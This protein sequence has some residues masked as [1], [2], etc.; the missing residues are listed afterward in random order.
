M[1]HSK[2]FSAICAAVVL[3]LFAQSASAQLNQ[4]NIPAQF[5]PGEEELGIGGTSTKL[6]VI[7]NAPGEAYLVTTG[8][9]AVFLNEV[10]KEV[11]VAADFVGTD[12]T[13][14]GTAHVVSVVK[15]PYLSG[16]QFCMK[17]TGSDWN[18]EPPCAPIVNG[19]SKVLIK[20]ATRG[21]A[22]VVVPVFKEGG[23]REIPGAWGAHAA[24]ANVIVKCPGM[25]KPDMG[26]LLFINKD[27]KISI[28]REM[29][30]AQK[31][32][33]EYETKRYAKFCKR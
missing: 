1:N 6:E 22:F 24:N 19:T 4:A 7:Q 30:N 31:M 12:A 33:K 10:P 21:Q 14:K 13:G 5:H 15:S 29:P 26:T 32:I 8:I 23:G 27:G 20:V 25:A 17:G 2:R 9:N 11:G 28:V 16:L 18:I 3:A